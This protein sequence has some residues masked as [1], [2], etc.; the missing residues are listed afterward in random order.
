MIQEMEKNMKI[1]VITGASS[2][3]GAEFVRQLDDAEHFDEIWV[4][5]RRKERLEQIK[6]KAPVRAIPL[7]LTKQCALD[8]YEALLKEYAPEIAVLVNASGFGYFRAFQEDPLENQLNMIDLN[9]KA[10]TAMTYISLK[11]MKSGS[12]IYNM[13]SMSSIQPVPYINVY[14]ATKAYVLSFSRALNVELKNSGIKVIAVCPYWVQT[15]FFDTAIN[16]DTVNN[17]GRIFTPQEVVSQALKDMKKGR[18][19][20][21]CGLNTKL[22]RLGVKLLPHSLVMKIWCKQQ[23]IN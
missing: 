19:V 21:F 15:E 12:R 13:G 10:L 11:Y 8:E 23:S 9:S 18:D 14:A 16:D 17:F 4:I 7:D 1:A 2:G 3:I 22:Q 5:A 6:A 20:S